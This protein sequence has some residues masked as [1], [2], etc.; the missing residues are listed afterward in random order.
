MILRA[1]REHSLNLSQ[2]ILVGDKVSDIEAGRAAGLGC[3]VLVLSG[4]APDSKDL[5]KVDIVFEDLPAVA[6][7]VVKNQLCV[8]DTN[9]KISELG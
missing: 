1:A 9:K 3:C 6:N 8:D 7:A 5:N 2:S 4:H